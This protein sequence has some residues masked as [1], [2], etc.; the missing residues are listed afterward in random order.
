RSAWAESEIQNSG[1]IEMMGGPCSSVQNFTNYATGTIKGCGSIHSSGGYIENKGLIWSMGG[2][3]ILSG[4]DPKKVG[5]N[6]SG[7]LRNSPGTSLTA[8]F[9]PSS[10][11]NLN[12]QGTIEINADGAVVFDCNNLNNE[13]NAVI[14][15]YGGTLST[16]TV[17]HKAG[18]TLEGFGGVTGNVVI[19]PNAAVRLTGSA[20]IVGDAKI[21]EGAT[22]EIGNGT[23]LI[24]GHT[25]CDG[26]IHMKGG[27]LIPQ[28]GLSGYCEIIWEPGAYANPADF[29]LDGKVGMTDFAA[30]ADTWLW[31]QAL[32]L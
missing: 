11:P 19:D 29:D 12:N 13:P 15:L 21:A 14:R 10:V 17:T 4:S 18:A 3:F 22:L 6:N 8:V 30:F 1:L 16:R 31:E 27:R 23:T 20:N 24:T 7:T 25:T 5:V 28:G 9:W 26:T 32:L 2:S